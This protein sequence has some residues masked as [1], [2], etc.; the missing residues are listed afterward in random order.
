MSGKAIQSADAGA[1]SICGFDLSEFSSQIA[2]A[3]EVD[4]LLEIALVVSDSM[5]RGKAPFNV[6]G[7]DSAGM[8]A[9]VVSSLAVASSLREHELELE[10]FADIEVPKVAEAY[11]HARAMS[12]LQ[13]EKIALLAC[14]RG[15]PYSIA[16]LKAAEIKAD[17]LL[18]ANHATDGV[19]TA[20]P[21]IDPQARMYKTMN[22]D[23]LLSGN[24]QVLDPTAITLCME[25][26]IPIHV[27]GIYALNAVFHA[28]LGK[29]DAGTYIDSSA[30]TRINAPEVSRGP[31]DSYGRVSPSPDD[32]YGPFPASHVQHDPSMN[33]ID[34]VEE[35]YQERLSASLIDVIAETPAD[36]LNVLAETILESTE[37]TGSS[38]KAQE[39]I[40]PHDDIPPFALDTLVLPRS[41]DK[42]LSQS[43]SL[44]RLL[45]YVDSIAVTDQVVLWAMATLDKA[46]PA[47]IKSEASATSSAGLQ[48][49]RILHGL[50]PARE[51]LDNKM[52]QLAK[53]P[54][55]RWNHA[56]AVSDNLPA[57]YAL[58]QAAPTILRDLLAQ[59]YER[60]VNF[61][62][63]YDRGFLQE[64]LDTDLAKTDYAWGVSRLA[65]FLVDR[66]YGA[67]DEQLI[68]YGVA[69]AVFGE[70]NL[71]N[72]YSRDIF[73][74]V[75]FDD[76]TYVNGLVP[77]A[78][79]ERNSRI[80]DFRPEILGTTKLPIS[81][82]ER[83]ELPSVL[84]DWPD[85][86]ALRKN[87]EVFAL[88][89]SALAGAM[90]MI[91]ERSEASPTQLAYTLAAEID[92]SVEP[93]L[94]QLETTVRRSSLLNSAVPKLAR[95]GF[96]LSARALPHPVLGIGSVAGRVGQ[97]AG[98][99]V[100]R[101]S[102]EREKAARVAERLLGALRT[103]A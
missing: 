86:I 27:F 11:T 29:H 85:L 35:F 75:A 14:A 34:Y 88:F 59:E 93:I 54:S 90:H 10:I 48:L 72:N 50:L 6:R 58:A 2:R 52:I 74:A 100:V 102:T 94:E 36:Q 69:R 76:F 16:A 3:R 68:I 25:N 66:Y 43:V 96:S 80:I 45:L 71:D 81:A 78:L 9:T 97:A 62:D 64:L 99:K 8:L 33:G 20:D 24:L 89:R 32:G 49:A 61:D 57:Q 55:I 38:A 65:D 98:D 39:S 70:S 56:M 30:P 67:L 92:Q 17:V 19:Y 1:G 28:L 79:R 44:R 21:R 22:Y 40:T 15:N 41:V 73:Q 46:D 84:V 23:Q 5:A 82:L 13:E 95:F 18:I 12:T 87:D 42:P 31:K 47:L 4:P 83:A 91:G 37:P 77:I 103:G 101:K 60:P 26:D 53:P 63:T 51:L 7:A